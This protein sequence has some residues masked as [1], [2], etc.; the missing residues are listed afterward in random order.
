MKFPS[1]LVLLVAVLA[2]FASAAHAY[3]KPPPKFPKLSD[4]D[5]KSLVDAYVSPPNYIPILFTIFRFEL[6]TMFF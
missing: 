1:L 5:M 4:E 3:R 6:K 2:L